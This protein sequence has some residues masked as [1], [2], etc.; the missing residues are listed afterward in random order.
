MTGDGEVLYSTSQLAAAAGY[1]VQ[2][3]RD[4]ERLGV[5]PAA[6]RKSNGYRAFEPVHLQALA[7]YRSLAVAIG[8]VP[9]R[10]RKSTRLNSS[11]V[12]NSYAAFCMKKTNTD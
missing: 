3:I 11:H 1:S 12:A 5:I 8:P 10:D 2:Q 9:A 7:V 6:R 4:L